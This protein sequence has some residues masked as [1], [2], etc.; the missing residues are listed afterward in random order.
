ML[1]HRYIT[2]GYVTYTN[3]SVLSPFLADLAKSAGTKSRLYSHVG[4]CRSQYK[5]GPGRQ[6]GTSPPIILSSSSSF[7]HFFV[8]H[9]YIEIVDSPCTL[10][11]IYCPE[12]LPTL[13]SN[14]LW[15][16]QSFPAKKEKVPSERAARGYIHTIQCSVCRLA[17]LQVLNNT[18]A[19]DR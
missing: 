18:A 11:W 14:H 12:L 1:N 15:C 6:A 3:V 13:I 9:F 2:Y 19:D 16:L 7:H 8:T 10:S 5:I 17:G 4:L